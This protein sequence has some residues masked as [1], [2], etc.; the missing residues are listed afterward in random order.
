[1]R[2]IGCYLCCGN[3]R[4]KFVFDQ[5]ISSLSAFSSLW[6]DEVHHQLLAKGALLIKDAQ[7]LDCTEYST[8]ISALVALKKRL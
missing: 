1:M 5:E 8:F 7:S 2:I 3:S 6:K 4:C